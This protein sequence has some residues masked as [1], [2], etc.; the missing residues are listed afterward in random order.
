MCSPIR[1]RLALTSTFVINGRS[2][3]KEGSAGALV[4]FP[5]PSGRSFFPSIPGYIDRATFLA[6]QARIDANVHPQPHQAGG[7]VR[8]GAALPGDVR[9]VWPPAAHSLHGQKRSP[10]LPLLRQQYRR[11][12]RRVLSPCGWGPNRSS[13]GGRFS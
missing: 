9:E 5:W 12:T 3:N 10:R 8:E 1:C 11:G 6:N 13:G 7:A 2:T 4:I